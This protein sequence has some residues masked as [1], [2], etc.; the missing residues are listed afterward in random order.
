MLNSSCS[1]NNKPDSSR[2]LPVE[3]AYNVRD[4]GGYPAADNKTV[5][6]RKVIRSGDLHLLTDKDLSYF[7]AI[8]L[9][10]YIDFRDSEEI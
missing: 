7:D 10:S 6:W 8:P 3:G 1:N 4:L 9:K 5:K 2:V